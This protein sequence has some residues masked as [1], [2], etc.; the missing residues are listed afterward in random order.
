TLWVDAG[1]RDR[2][3]IPPLVDVGV[4]Q[5]VVGLET[6][7]GPDRLREIVQR[8]GTSRL[9]FSLD[10]KGDRP[11]VSAEAVWGTANP[12]ELAE[13]VLGI[14]VDKLLILD[15]SLVGTERGIGHLDLLSSLKEAHPAAEIIVGGGVAGPD[16]LS[17][18]AQSGASA[19][20]VA[21][22]LHDGKI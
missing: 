15:L 12:H 6:L 19:V 5:I 14:G 22:A 11:L 2:W 10:L 13:L 17:I 3:S 16:D 18:L 9:V 1:I 4:A 7:R 8:Y 20:L 21:S